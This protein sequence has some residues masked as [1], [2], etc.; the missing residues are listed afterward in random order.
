MPWHRGGCGAHSWA[1]QWRPVAALGAEAGQGLCQGQESGVHRRPRPR[2]FQD[3][4]STALW[5][6]ECDLAQAAIQQG[7]RLLPSQEPP[8]LCT[9][10]KGPRTPLRQ[11][12]DS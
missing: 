2:L 12:G 8:S 9:W 1:H 5:S 6:A 10:A 3:T 11:A 7:C 4:V